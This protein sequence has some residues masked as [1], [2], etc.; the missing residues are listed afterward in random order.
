MSLPAEC[1]HVSCLSSTG[2][3]EHSKA[4]DSRE[5][6]ISLDIVGRI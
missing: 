5:L 4:T 3:H 2:Y 1:Q 6:G